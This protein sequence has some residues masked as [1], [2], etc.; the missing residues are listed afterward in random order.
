MHELPLRL[1]AFDGLKLDQHLTKFD[2]IPV[3][4]MDG[5]HTGIPLGSQRIFHFHRFEKHEGLA[6]FDDLAF[7]DF[8]GENFP[9]HGGADL[10]FKAPPRPPLAGSSVLRG[11]VIE[12]VSPP[13]DGYQAAVTIPDHMGMK[14]MTIN[15]EGDRT[16]PDSDHMGRLLSLSVPDKLVQILTIIALVIFQRQFFT[17]GIE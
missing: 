7:D 14:R 11:S 4:H 8:D 1:P 17:R 16:I 13:L 9:W 6:V 12:F 15:E 3:G 2:E 5:G 10:G